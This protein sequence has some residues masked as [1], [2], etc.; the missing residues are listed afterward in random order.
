MS[1]FNALLL[2]AG[3][4]TR[5]RPLTEHC[6]K[7][8]MPIAGRPLLEHWLCSL[9]RIGIGRVIVNMYHH[10]VLVESFLARSCFSDWV[11]G[12]LEHKL[13]GTAGTLR[14]NSKSLSVGTT[15]V[16]HADNWCQCNLR[17]FLDYHQYLRPPQT[18]MTMMTFRTSTPTSC[19]IV[20]IDNKGV[21]QHFHEKTSDARGNLAN[22][23]VYL[24]EPEVIDW[25]TQTFQANDF[26]TEVLP[27]FVG[28]IA[29]WENTG[30][31]RDIGAIS[32]LIDAQR[33]P[34][35]NLCWPEI[36]EWMRVY[37]NNPV[38]D[39]FIAA[40]RQV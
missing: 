35:Q 14:E 33:D 37:Q 21:V 29:T 17:D 22:G 25:T 36:D 19:G 1:E 31:H 9:Y 26:S 23:A 13:L 15:L 10:H 18:L 11:T 27:E 32:S 39:Q 12:V 20:E 2:A 5:L 6:P 3:L 24:L 28:R 30:I 38:H 4:G 16:A 7:C 40:T 34:Q 8:L